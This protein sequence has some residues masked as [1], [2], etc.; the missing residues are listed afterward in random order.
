MRTL[1]KKK[2]KKKK[3]FIIIII[4]I[5]RNLTDSGQK[6]MGLKQ[7]VGLRVPCQDYLQ[8]RYGG[9]QYRNPEVSMQVPEWRTGHRSCTC[10][11]YVQAWGPVVISSL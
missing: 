2:K 5:Y 8:P 6:N 9:S 11:F 7:N 1:K 4:I 10:C 3:Q